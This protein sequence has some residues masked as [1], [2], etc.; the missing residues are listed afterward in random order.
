MMTDQNDMSSQLG[1]M[2]RNISESGAKLLHSSNDILTTSEDL[3]NV[4]NDL[5]GRPTPSPPA[6]EE[7]SANMSTVS[8]TMDHTTNQVN[9]MA[10]SVEDDRHG[11]DR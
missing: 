9:M 7:M 5:S 4:F 3:S 2:F 11:A 1:T 6:S 8:N 10:A